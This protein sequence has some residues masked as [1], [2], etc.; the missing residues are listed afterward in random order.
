MREAGLNRKRPRGSLGKGRRGENILLEGDHF[1]RRRG[2][3][4]EGRKG[5][6]NH[7]KKRFYIALQE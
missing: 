2:G 4:G 5:A 3:A 6:G 7:G 1:G